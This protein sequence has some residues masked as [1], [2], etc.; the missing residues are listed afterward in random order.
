MF[1][2]L[3][4]TVTLIILLLSPDAFPQENTEAQHNRGR[5]SAS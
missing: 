3:K 1:R 5:S 4:L 2:L